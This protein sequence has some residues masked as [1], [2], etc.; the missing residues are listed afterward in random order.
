MYYEVHG[1]A[2]GGTTGRPYLTRHRKQRKHSLCHLRVFLYKSVLE[3]GRSRSELAMQ[4]QLGGTAPYAKQ[5]CFRL[6]PAKPL[7]ARFPN[8]GL[9]DHRA[10]RCLQEVI[11]SRV[12]VLQERNNILDLYINMYSILP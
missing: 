6:P 7:L 12:D 10:L 3:D 11:R 5:Q 2:L 9:S 4:S 8:N 1:F